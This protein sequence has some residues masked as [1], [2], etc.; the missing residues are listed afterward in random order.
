L[1][2]LVRMVVVLTVICT[3][4][5]VVLSYVNKATVAPREYQLLKYVQEPSIKAVLGS[6]NYDNDPIQDRLEVIVGKDEEGHPLKVTVFPAKKGG[7]V[8]GVAYASKAKGYHDMIEV[9]V[10]VGPN[11]KLSGISIMSHSETPGLGARIT[12]PQFT[13]QFAGLDLQTAKLTA[14]GGQVDAVSGASYSSRG[15]VTAV[16]KALQEFAAIKKEAFKP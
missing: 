3:T 5:G 9:M 4:S 13:E 7:K 2:D 14:D 15:V 11:A 12:E 8:L 6:F 10:G 16:D 1:R